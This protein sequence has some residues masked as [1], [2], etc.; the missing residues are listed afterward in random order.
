MPPY[1]LYGVK[2]IDPVSLAPFSALETL[3]SDFPPGIT[4]PYS[5]I[6][7]THEN[8]SVTNMSVI[9]AVQGAPPVSTVFFYSFAHIRYYYGVISPPGAFF[10]RSRICLRQQ[11]TPHIKFHL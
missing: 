5:L 8:N 3:A 7:K 4:Y 6:I 9:T 11:A 2:Y 1:V 10:I